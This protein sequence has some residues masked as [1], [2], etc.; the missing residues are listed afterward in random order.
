MHRTLVIVESPAKCKKIETYLGADLYRVMASFGHV[1]A[2]ESLDAINLDTFE[3][4]YA[5]TAT[6]QRL[7]EL[8]SAVT[9]AGGQVLLATDDDREG[10]AIAW[11][12]CI[13]LGLPVATTPRIVF[14]E[15]T[16]PALR[17]AVAAPRRLDMDKV[18]SQRTR[19][20]IDLLVG[21]Q[22][23]PVLWRCIAP[24][25]CGGGGGNKQGNGGSAGGGGLSAGRCQTPALRLVYENHL[26]LAR[27]RAAN[28]SS[29]EYVC[30]ASFTPLALP[31]VRESAQA[32]VVGANAARALLTRL[33]PLVS[34][35][36]KN[37]FICSVSEPKKSQRRAPEPFTTSTLQQC[38]SNEL[39]MSP[40]ETM[41]LAQQLYEQ[42]L[43]TYMRTD[44]KKYSAVF[45]GA[46]Q[47]RIEQT[48]GAAFVSPTLGALVGAAAAAKPKKGKEGKEG[49]AGG[50]SKAQE[51]HEAIRPTHLAVESSGSAGGDAAPRLNRLYKLI[52]RR[53]LESCMAPAQYNVVSA[54]AVL[55]PEHTAAGVDA[56][57]ATWRHS[58]EECVFLGWQAVAAAAAATSPGSGTSAAYSFLRLHW[59]PRPVF[60]TPTRLSAE[61]TLPS[62]GS[63]YTEARLIQLLEEKGIGRPST[64]ASLVDK[65]QER[66]YVEKRDVDG[67]TVACV[68][69]VLA[70]AP[71]PTTQQQQQQPWQ[72]T[73]TQCSRVFGRET[74][75]L[76]VTQ[77]GVVVIEFL[78]RHFADLFAYEY[79]ARMET[80]L[81]LIAHGELPWADMCR[82]C[83]AHLVAL[84][85]ATA[86]AGRFQ[87]QLDAQHTLVMTRSGAAIR[88][89]AAVPEPTTVADEAAVV[90]TDNEKDDNEVVTKPKKRKRAT[91]KAK[92]TWLPVKKDVDLASLV[93]AAE[94][95]TNPEMKAA[96]SISVADIVDADAVQAALPIGQYQGEDLFVKSGPYG[97]YAQW[98]DHKQSLRGLVPATTKGK[99]RQQTTTRLPIPK[100]EYANVVAFLE[101]AVSTASSAASKILRTV[102]DNLSVRTGPYGQYLFYK[103]TTMKTPKFISL[104]EFTEHDALTCEPAL[105]DDW[106]HQ[107]ASKPKRAAGKWKARYKK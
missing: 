89:D 45:V 77:L 20:I 51:A 27:K 2:L 43:I 91:P 10:E 79:T 16:E 93:V 101:S 57:D 103:T 42:G 25:G 63:H 30:T 46:A 8:R 90:E 12:L 76:V 53:A 21:F 40:K 49:A 52:Y 37:A 94:A 18:H 80:E 55:A 71:A 13:L 62:Q 58:A 64:F 9:A 105:L 85:A 17:A 73:E 106:V 23:S 96:A 32:P 22:V 68:D 31:F 67:K 104:K 70:P 87:V 78:T 1:R 83:H 102:S 65:I 72:V 61:F 100:L 34:G 28:D 48:W 99:G 11:H 35:G 54:Q 92:P 26:E 88:V 3:A 7:A 19:Q 14:N 41:R 15:I 69:F 75:K 107:Q 44:S 86:G 82:Q 81:D 5:V 50:G 56:P 6:R 38:A 60:G 29:G 39:H 4:D 66:G 98:G 74:N 59:A 24:G 36:A 97:L 95:E 84:V 47:K 33:Q